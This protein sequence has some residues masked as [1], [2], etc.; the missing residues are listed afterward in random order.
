MD[1]NIIRT[2]SVKANKVLLP[3]VPET[4][5]VNP[6]HQETVYIPV[7]SYDDEGI[8]SYDSEYF[9]VIEGKVKLKKTYAE[10][11]A[12]VQQGVLFETYDS[13]VDTLEL[14][15]ENNRV[16]HISNA[17][18]VVITVTGDVLAYVCINFKGILDPSIVIS[19]K[20]PIYSDPLNRTSKDSRW[21]F[22]IDTRMSIVGKCFSEVT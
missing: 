18:N 6:Y 19:A 5:R 8:A 12:Q 21:E 14:K 15:V 13:A 2:A 10:L 9:S 3:V 17:R 16:Y 20:V 4:P 11:L 22:S 1:N 7:A